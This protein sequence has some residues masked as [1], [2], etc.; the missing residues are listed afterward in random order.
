M[1]LTLGVGVGQGVE[2]VGFS[3]ELVG[4]AIGVAVGP[5]GIRRWSKDSSNTGFWS[6]TM[7]P[8]SQLFAGID[9]AYLVVVSSL[10]K[11]LRLKKQQV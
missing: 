10:F 4:L 2:Y 7:V 9:S 5:I 1:I 11:M 8:K 6:H 3:V